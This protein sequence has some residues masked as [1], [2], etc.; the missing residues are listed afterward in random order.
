MPLR[1]KKI[2]IFVEKLFEDLE[3]WY[4]YLRMQEAGAEVIAVAPKVDTYEG[5]NGLTVKADQSI[6]GIDQREFNALIIPGGYS[7]DHMR[8]VPEMIDFVKRMYEEEKLIAAICHA[9][10]MLASAGILKG[11]KITSYPSIKDDLINAGA[12]WSDCDV[13]VDGR[14]ITSRNPK[15]LPVF[16]KSIIKCLS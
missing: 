13:I 10:W 8:R 9:P 14:I 6:V 2:A 16:C 4:P 11:K 15:D 12:E 3:F 7:P 1:G 5:K